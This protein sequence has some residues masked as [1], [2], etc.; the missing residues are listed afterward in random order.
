MLLAIACLL[1]DRFSSVKSESAFISQRTLK[2]R[3]CYFALTYA[4]FIIILFNGISNIWYTGARAYSISARALRGSIFSDF[5][6]T[7]TLISH[8]KIFK[9]RLETEYFSL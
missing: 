7:A 5:L 2:T 3:F 1:K 9:K 4:V 8:Q 6:R